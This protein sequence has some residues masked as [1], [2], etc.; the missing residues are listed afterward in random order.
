M[1]Q[2]NDLTVTDR[3]TIFEQLNMH[4]RCIDKGWGREQ[5]DLY[6][7]LYWAEA[8]FNVNDLRTSTFEGPDGMKQMFDYAHSV[9]PMDKW[10]HSMGAFEISGSG[11]RAEA[12][13]RWVV[14]WKAEHVGTV[15]TGTYD[16]IFE[17][18]DGIWKC[19]ERTSKT[20]PNWPEDLFGPFFDA[21]DTTFKAS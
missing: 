18:R 11:D 14:S 4:Q 7:R 16:D 9:F 13:W 15:S 6:N 12:H 2:N 5:V 20:D 10:F 3:F 21:A 19:L 17:R 8:K 1:S